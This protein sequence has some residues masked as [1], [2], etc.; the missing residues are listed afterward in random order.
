[1]RSLVFLAISWLVTAQVGATSF[2]LAVVNERIDQSDYVLNQYR[3]LLERLGSRLARWGIKVAP[4]VIAKDLNDLAGIV[5]RGEADA[6]FESLFPTLYLQHRGAPLDISLIA[7]RRG[8][9]ETSSL[10]F[11]RDDSPV[12]RLEDLR[13]QTLALESRRSTTA[14]ALPR[15]ALQQRGLRSVP[16]EGAAA[17]D[18]DAVR[19][20]FA[21][22]EENQAY[23]VAH[24]RADAAAFNAEDWADL[25]AKLRRELRV[26]HTTDPILRWLVSF[27]RKAS[28]LVRRTVVE[29]LLAASDDPAGLEV[30]AQARGI[31]KFERPAAADEQAIARWR[32]IAQRVNFGQ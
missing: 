24:G 3:P 14:F 25:P 11:V 8:A 2:T 4:L 27:H 31:R 15:A 30:L 12:R 22:S 7:W 10:F 9:R 5:S 13:G 21:G 23:W 32:D 26:V 17:G 1:M 29:E 16:A 18:R 20:V 6:V 19:F 28:P